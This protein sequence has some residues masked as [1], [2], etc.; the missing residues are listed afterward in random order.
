MTILLTRL[1]PFLFCTLTSAFVLNLTTPISS[2]Q[3]PNRK[4]TSSTSGY[5]Q[6]GANANNLALDAEC[7]GPA[8]GIG[9]TKE[10]CH[11]A[12][13]FG[14]PDQKLRSILQYGDRRFGRFD[15][16]LPQRYISGKYNFPRMRKHSFVKD[17]IGDGRCVV[18]VTLL[19]IHKVTPYFPLGLALAATFVGS[20]C[21]GELHPPQGGTLVRFGKSS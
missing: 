6:L 19:D 13:M 1:N 12:I 16:N 2:H 10:N 14:I 4:N 9:L 17:L 18:D 5:L 15:I 20:K 8:S 3:A 7:N 11:D 21:V